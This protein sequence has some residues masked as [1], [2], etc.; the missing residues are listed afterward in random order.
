V[1]VP[2]EDA[3]RCRT[4]EWAGPAA[5]TSFVGCGLTMSPCDRAR[6]VIGG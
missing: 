4:A 1:R 5:E 6:R 3:S 2:D